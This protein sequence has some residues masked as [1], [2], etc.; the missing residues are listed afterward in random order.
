M[1]QVLSR[2]FNT[3]RVARFRD[4]GWWRQEMEN[5]PDSRY[6][7]DPNSSLKNETFLIGLVR[8]PYGYYRSLF[9]MLVGNAYP[10]CKLY[11]ATNGTK[12]DF[13]KCTCG[14]RR[15][16]AHGLSWLF[17]EDNRN[18]VSAFT[19]WL[20]LVL[21][22]ERPDPMAR[23]IPRTQMSACAESMQH[24]HN[25]LMLM[26]DGSMAYDA[27]IRQERYYPSLRE[28]LQKVRPCAPNNVTI[29]FSVLDDFE[30]MERKGERFRGGS[31]FVF[32]KA[33]AKK[34]GAV[35][36]VPDYCFY[37]PQLRK[38]VEE[39]DNEYMVRYGYTWENFVGSVARDDCNGIQ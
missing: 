10:L 17:H 23:I 22:D 33:E 19:Q 12:G 30:E 8:N 38:K 7:R 9:G 16:H 34:V 18:N 31:R 32:A 29:D 25:N 6:N 14:M 37:S 13:G 27:V 15:A 24:R 28:A 11:V 20:E 26:N 1:R 2:V 39:H 5:Q 35:S 4:I 36:A 21:S 3:T